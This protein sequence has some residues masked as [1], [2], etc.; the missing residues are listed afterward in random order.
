MHK[1]AGYAAITNKPPFDAR[2]RATNVRPASQ[3]RLRQ[4]RQMP[5]V[6]DFITTF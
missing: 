5:A 6:G 1:G 4:N 3:A 2:G